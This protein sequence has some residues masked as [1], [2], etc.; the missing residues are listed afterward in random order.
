MEVA[1]EAEPRSPTLR[2]TAVEACPIA[3]TLW[4]PFRFGA[5][6]R[7]KS[8]NVVIRIRSDAGYVGYGEACPVPQLTSETQ[9]SIVELIEGTVAPLLMGKDPRDWRATIAETTRTLSST[10]FTAAAV[11]V[12]LLDLAGKTAG[13]SVVELLGG[14]LRSRVEVHGSVGWF[15]D[16]HEM[17]E[18]AEAQAE[19]FRM[20][21]L[22]AGVGQLPEDLERLR[23]VRERLNGDHPF[24]VD[25]NGMWSGAEALAAAPTLQELGVVL[26]EQP[27]ASDHDPRE[28]VA[29]SEIYRREWGIAIVAD[30]AIRSAADAV[31]VAADRRAHIAN[32]GCSK[33]GG[34]VAALD[35]AAT[36]TA[37]GLETL[38]G[39]VVELGIATAAGLH[40]SAALPSL[41]Y[42]AYLSGSLK[43]VE[44]ITSPALIPVGSHLEVPTGDG[45]GVEVDEEAL[46]VLDARR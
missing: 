6:E 33:L 15:A 7:T 29:V 14:R 18:A 28:A 32:I 26:L 38:V 30:E 27:L 43:Y 25:V 45:L 36:A 8:A 39:S 2:I 9:Q 31:S 3:V 37:V 17:C 19:Q 24:L 16:P 13:L 21:K 40:L 5:V 44:Q 10:P 12:A 23:V 34:V 20:L 4:K 42:P 46:H 22:Y 11:D 35:V 1:R 41:T